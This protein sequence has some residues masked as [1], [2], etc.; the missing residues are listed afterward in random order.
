MESLNG[1]I[2]TECLYCK[3]GKMQRRE[4]ENPEKG[5]DGCRDRIHRVLHQKRFLII[6]LI[7]HA[8]QPQ[9]DV[10]TPRVISIITDDKVS[11]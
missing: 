2:K 5:C 1:I 4:P 8:Q 11:C 6:R 10:F 3:F 7:D 9:E